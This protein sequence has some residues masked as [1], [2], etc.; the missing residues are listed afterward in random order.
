MVSLVACVNPDDPDDP[1]D[2]EDP[3]GD[4]KIDYSITVVDPFGAPVPEMIVTIYDGETEVEM[5]LTNKNGV[6][7][8]KNPLEGAS[9]TFTVSDPKGTKFAYDES[10][11]VLQDDVTED[12]TVVLYQSSENLYT[13]D[14]YPPE[15]TS[16]EPV[17]APAMVGEGGYML[18][19]EKGRNYFIF[20]PTERGKCTISVSSS[21]TVTIGY[22]GGPH[23]VQ[24]HNLASTDGSGEVYMDGTTKICFNIRSY[25]VA[26]SGNGSSRYVIMIESS[27]A[28]KGFITFTYDPNLERNASELPWSEY[29]L[30]ND[31]D[32]YTVAGKD[33]AGF[34]L[35]DVDIT[36]KTLTIVYNSADKL[37]HV[38]SVDGPVLLLRVT[39]S[40]K[41]LPSLE[42]VM[43]TDAFYAYVY[44]AD[45]NLVAK[46]DYN[47]MMSKYIA[48][49]DPD[50]GVIPLDEHLVNA[51]TDCGIAKG[52]FD[53][54]G[55][56]SSIIFGDDLLLLNPDLVL[57]F[58][59][60]Y[61][62]G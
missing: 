20:T 7:A 9:F 45:G 36:S 59:C 54:G 42:T 60:C 16:G 35:T 25:N 51:L 33:Q 47:E 18:D 50:L 53:R 52:W 13:E 40:S 34:A 38:G 48:A 3:V 31:P 2:P 10:I 12:V 57:Y 28:A 8:A 23:L 1:E 61:Y 44:G 21:A 5:R 30:Q 49:A 39:S 41:Y 26:T 27:E 22:H 19:L 46:R 62:A 58:A 4:G 6:A 56:S 29:I 37:Y 14:I 11:C 24:T 32:A 15:I 55:G 17:E 43:E